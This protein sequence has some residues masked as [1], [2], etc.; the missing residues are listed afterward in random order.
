MATKP[1]RCNAQCILPRLLISLTPQLL[2]SPWT[3]CQVYLSSQTVRTFNVLTFWLSPNAKQS[4][5]V[6]CQLLLRLLHDWWWYGIAAVEGG[7][8][9]HQ[10]HT[11]P[12]L[13]WIN[14]C[15]L[16]WVS[17]CQLLYIDCCKVVGGLQEVNRCVGWSQWFGHCIGRSLC[18]LVDVG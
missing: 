18:Q 1:K 6:P 14:L 2:F 4:L 16:L 9:K 3:L 17:C 7:W 12:Q 11:S 10:S 8:C 15:H 5:L 13:N